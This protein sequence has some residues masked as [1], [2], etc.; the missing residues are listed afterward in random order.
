MT[1]FWSYICIGWSFE[2]I[3]I[4]GGDAECD[5]CWVPTPGK[6]FL[7]TSVIQFPLQP[8]MSGGEAVDI[9]AGET[10]KFSVTRC[11]MLYCMN[12]NII[13]LQITTMSGQQTS[14]LASC[15]SK[16]LQTIHSHDLLNNVYNFQFPVSYRCLTKYYNLWYF[17]YL[18][19]VDISSK[20]D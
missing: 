8:R 19:V 6:L 9:N 17:R 5:K 13:I 2:G 3:T 4:I 20:H 12:I 15:K 16:C 11:W 14:G 1:R 18:D 10:I 7:V